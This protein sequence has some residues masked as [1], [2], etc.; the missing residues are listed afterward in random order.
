MFGFLHLSPGVLL[1]W[2][3]TAF[4]YGFF[5][6]GTRKLTVIPSSVQNIIEML[7]ESL[8]S[9][10][11]GLLG[12]NKHNR[13]LIPFFATIFLYLLCAN[14]MG[15]IPG[16]K[17]PTGIFS[18]CLGMALIT[19]FMTH[20]LGLKYHGFGYIKHFWGEPAW[21]GPLM[22]PIH[23]IGEIARPI[24]LSFRL[25]GNILGEDVVAIVLTVAIFPL[26]IP[27]PMQCLMI[28]TSLIQA[29]VFTILSCIYIKGAVG[30][31][32]H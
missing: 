26:L 5:W 21:L 25:F 16:L 23:I 10:L 19:F 6:L 1:P 30:S 31:E 24:S 13:E 32:E 4:L 8:D 11:T 12:D 28:F 20:Y 18:N 14:L 22:F 2:V 7:V 9:F 29:L 15:L 27:I 17:S 3:I